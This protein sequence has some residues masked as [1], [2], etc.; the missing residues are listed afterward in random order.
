[1]NF[2]VYRK[3]EYRKDIFIKNFNLLNEAEEYVLKNKPNNIDYY[4]IVSF[5]D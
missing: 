2:L 1:M 5:H 3:M 4:I